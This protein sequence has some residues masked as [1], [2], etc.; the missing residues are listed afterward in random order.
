[1]AIKGRSPRHFNL[2]IGYLL[3]IYWL[4]IGY[5]LAIHHPD[6]L[7]TAVTNTTR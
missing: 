3:V 6:W 2:F 4:F 5:L 7:P 1:M